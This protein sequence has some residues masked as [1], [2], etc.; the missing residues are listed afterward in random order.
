[1]TERK[2][3]ALLLAP[4]RQA[5]SGV[6]THLNLLLG[7]ALA[8][9]FAL[10]HFQVGSEGRDESAP[11]RFWRLLSSPLILAL[12]IL[13]ANADLVHINTSMNPR[14]W[15]RDLAYLAV[16][17]LSGARVVY[18]VHGGDL[19]Q[20]FATVAHVP[21]GVL[22][23]ILMLPDAIVVL[24]GSEL[25]AYRKFVPRQEI[26]VL[27]NGID[28]RSCR[29]RMHPSH[30][31]PAPLQ[32][33]YV[34]RLAPRK[35][36]QETIEG[37]AMA[38]ARGVSATLVVAGSGPEEPAL[39]KLVVQL[40]LSDVVSFVGPVFDGEKRRLFEASDLLM[41]PSHFEGLPYALLEGMAA[42]VPV[43]AT[44][45]GAIPD[46]VEHGMHGL[47]VPVGNPRAICHAIVRLSGDRARLSAMG[48]ASRR[49]VIDSYSIERLAGDFGKLYRSLC[50]A[51]HAPLSGAS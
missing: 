38:R 43:I 47:F 28:V 4:S 42:G 10:I 5:I 20:K 3:V 33:V 25:A 2:P 24:A 11:G 39:R 6:T 27:P 17:K 37:L 49:R 13:L 26:L 12:R 36:L 23:F 19:P 7:S 8:R 35:G 31:H 32:L 51:G 45:V 21:A 15:W 48:V 34:G 9:E 22:R 41:L 18:Q 40:G 16:A 1:M 29:D 14:A 44:R 46:V 30:P 50:G